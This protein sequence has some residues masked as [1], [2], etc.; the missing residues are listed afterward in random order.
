M[1]R[2]TGRR[3]TREVGVVFRHRQT[4][5]W[6]LGAHVRRSIP[7]VPR[8]LRERIGS[9]YV[10]RAPNSRADP[11]RMIFFSRSMSSARRLGAYG[12]TVPAVS[13]GVWAGVAIS[14]G[15]AVPLAATPLALAVAVSAGYGGFRPGPLCLPP[16]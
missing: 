13:L 16:T 15:G 1:M 9:C 12:L 11:S 5:Q 2:S 7:G 14:R 4:L 6:R 8:R 10:F 3:N